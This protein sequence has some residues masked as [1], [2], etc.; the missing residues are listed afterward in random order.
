MNRGRKI[1]RIFLLPL[2]ILGSQALAQ[3]GGGGKDDVFRGKLFPPNVIMEHREALDLT[4]EQYTGIRQ[5]VVAAQA[6]IAEH[7]WDL[8]EAYQRVLA[9]L[10]ESPVDKDEVLG[11][12]DSALAAENA[13][14]L[15][16]VG[17]LIEIRNLLTQSQLS[18]LRELT[19]R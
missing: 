4:R 11:Y 1:S 12:V 17:L 19:A 16:Q 13:V 5:A 10:D 7:E 2:L 18:R 3:D 6:E 9:A 8:Q 14:K 15:R